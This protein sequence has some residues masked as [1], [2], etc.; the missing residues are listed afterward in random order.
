MFKSDHKDVSG[1]SRTVDDEMESDC[2][3]SLLSAGRF[4]SW[5]LCG[6]TPAARRVAM[7]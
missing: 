7:L 3:G 2:T 1:T 5:V 6:G 4:I